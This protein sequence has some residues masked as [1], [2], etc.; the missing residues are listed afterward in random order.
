MDQ[1]SFKRKLDQMH[2]EIKAGKYENTGMTPEQVS[3][4]LVVDSGLR[5]A[6]LPVNR[7]TQ[8]QYM[9]LFEPEFTTRYKMEQRGVRLPT[10]QELTDSFAQRQYQNYFINKWNEPERPDFL[11]PQQMIEYNTKKDRANWQEYLK[12]LDADKM[13]SMVDSSLQNI[14]NEI[15]AAQQSVNTYQALYDEL[16]NEIKNYDTRRF[17]GITNKSRGIEQENTVDGKYY[18]QVVQGLEDAKAYLSSLE[19]LRSSREIEAIKDSY[20]GLDYEDQMAAVNEALAEVRGQKSAGVIMG[21]AGAAARENYLQNEDALRRREDVLED[22]RQDFQADRYLTEQDAARARLENQATRTYRT[23]YN[24]TLAAIESEI[25]KAREEARENNEDYTYTYTLN[26]QEVIKLINLTP[27][28]LA[29]YE[30][31]RKYDTAAADEYKKNLERTVNARKAALREADIRDDG[32]FV[33]LLRYIGGFFASVG[34][35]AANSLGVIRELV[36]DEYVPPDLNSDIYWGPQT[37]QTVREAFDEDIDSPMLSTIVQVGLSLTDTMMLAPF[38]VGAAMA[39]GFAS[40]RSDYTYDALQRGATF[41]EAW[42]SGIA[43]GLAET[44]AEIIPLNRIFRMARAGGKWLS[45]EGLGNIL[46]TAGMEASEETLSQYLGTVADIKIMGSRSQFVQTMQ[47]YIAAGMSEGDAY[48]A[49]VEDYFVYQPLLAAFGG[50]I[51]GAAFGTGAQG[52][53]NLRLWL[54]KRDLDRRRKLDEEAA[55]AIEKKRAREGN[56]DEQAPIAE[57]EQESATEAQTGL[58]TDRAADNDMAAVDDVMPLNNNAEADNANAEAG[59]SAAQPHTITDERQAWADAIV[60][61]EMAEEEAE[62]E[63]L[64]P[65]N[66]LTGELAERVTGVPQAKQETRQAP[67]R[68]KNPYPAVDEGDVGFGEGALDEMPDTDPADRFR[69]DLTKEEARVSAQQRRKAKMMVRALRNKGIYNVRVEDLPEGINGYYDAQTRSIVVSSRLTNEEAFNFALGHEVVHHAATADAD[70][71]DDV[72]SS[73]RADGIDVDARIAA[74]IARYR[75]HAAARGED[76][77]RIDERYAMEEVV[78]DY[79]GEICRNDAYLQQLAN[80]QPN[81]LVRILRMLEEL[82]DNLGRSREEINKAREYEAT[83]S[84]VQEALV[85]AGHEEMIEGERRYSIDYDENNRPFVTVEEDILAGVP[86]NKWVKTVKDNLRKK[87]PNSIR[88]GNNEIDINNQSRREL[89]FSR[90]MQYLFRTDR[91]LFKDKL[92]ATNNADEILQ[93]SRNWVNEALIHPRKDAIIDFARGEVLLRIGGRDYTAQVIVGNRGEGNLLLYDIINLSP[94]SIRRRQET[95]ANH[96]TKPHDEAGNRRS[97]PVSNDSILAENES[98]NR[99]YSLGEENDPDLQRAIEMQQEGYSP[100]DISNA[101][102]KV[103]MANGDI[104]SGIGGVLQY[105]PNREQGGDIGGR[106]E[107][108]TGRAGTYQGRAD[109]QDEAGQGLGEESGG[110]RNDDRRRNRADGGRVREEARGWE[111]LSGEQQREFAQIVERHLQA[112]PGSEVEMMLNA[113]ESADNDACTNI[114][115]EIYNDLAIHPALVEDRWVHFVTD[116]Q[117]MIA[118][119]DQAAARNNEQ[120]GLDQDNASNQRRYSLAKDEEKGAGRRYA[121][122]KK[123]GRGKQ[124]QSKKTGKNQEA[125]KTAEKKANPTRAMS[126]S[127]R[128]LYRL[129]NDVGQKISELLSIPN[130]A[131][132]KELRPILQKLAEE[133]R[134]TGHIS[135]ESIKEA[136][137]QAYDM[138]LI[139]DD[140]FYNQYR[141]LKGILRD[142]RITISAE[143]AANIEDYAQW[144]KKQFNKLRIVNKGGEPI[145]SFYSELAGMYPELFDPDLLSPS[146]QLQRMAEVADMIVKVEERLDDAYGDQAEQFKAAMEYEFQQEI[147]GMIDELALIKRFEESL[148]EQRSEKENPSAPRSLETMSKIYRSM[149]A[150]RR[151]KDKAVARNLLTQEDNKAVDGLLKGYYTEENLPDG[152]NRKGVLEVYRAKKEYEDLAQLIDENRKAIVAA[153]TAVVERLLETSDSWKDKKTG[154]AYSRETMERNIQDIVPD[155]DV[156]REIINTIFKPI[157]ANEAKRT[158]MK[159]EYRDRI[160][161]LK[162]SRKAAAGNRNSEAYAVQFLGEA[163]SAIDYLKDKDPNA[164]EGGLTYKEWVTAKDEFLAANPNLDMKKIDHAIAEFR[165][166]YNELFEMVNAARLRNGYAPI[167]YRRGY[168]P[169][170]MENVPDSIFG[171]MG[172]AMGINVDVVDLP[173]DI[174]GLTHMF[175]PG[176]RWEGHLLPRKSNETDYDALAGF[177]KYIEGISDI[178]FHTD[179]IQMLRIL[180]TSLRVKYGSRALADR[181]KNIQESNATLEDKEAELDELFKT[182]VLTG[183]SNFVVAIRDYTN[184]LA[185][186]KSFN[187]REMEKLASRRLYNIVKNLENLVGV[188]MVGVNPASWLTNLIP[189]AQGSAM[190]RRGFLLR[191]MWDTLR[192]Y[193]NDD[194]FWMLSDFLVNRRGSVPLALTLM[195]RAGRTAS[196]GME[197]IDQFVSDSLVRARYAQNKADGLSDAEAMAEANAF[198]ANVIADRSKGALP[199]FFESK[200]PIRK[201]FTM[202]QVEVNNQLSFLF[203]DLPREARREGSKA[204]AAMFLQ[205]ALASWLFDEIYELLIGRRPALDPVNIL[206]DFVGDITGYQLPNLLS[207]VGDAVS[208]EEIEWSTDQEGLGQSFVNFLEAGAENVPFVGGL[209]GGGRLPVQ[210]AIPNVASLMEAVGDLI[211]GDISRDKALNNILDELLPALSYLATPFGGGALKKIIEGSVAV[212]QDGSYTLDNEGNKILQYPIYNDSTLQTIGNFIKAITF[213]KSSLSTGVAWVDDN[214][215]NLSARETAAYLNLVGGGSNVEDVYETLRAMKAEKK[216]LDKRLELMD[217]PL[218][219]YEKLTIYETVLYNEGDSRPEDIENIMATGVSFDDAM[220][221]QNK[222]NILDDIDDMTAKEKAGEFAYW[223]DSN[224]FTEDQQAVAREAFKFYSRIE[225][226]PGEINYDK[227]TAAGLDEDVAH[228]VEL[229]LGSL[230]PLIGE[231]EVLDAQKHRAIADL[232]ISDNDKL[233]AF[234]GIMNESSYKKISI[235]YDTGVEPGDYVTFREYLDE[236]SEGDNAT[237][238]EAVKA[239]NRMTWLSASEKAVLYQLANS[240][241]VPKNNPYSTAIGSRVY[242]SLK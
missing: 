123:E 126:K 205:F 233:K 95:G 76:P 113:Y 68:E 208:G 5:K 82:L 160:R 217:A 210:T 52:V 237:Q 166:I 134:R 232:D 163:N 107:Q 235:A 40:A 209:L 225:A 14:D 89:T 97:A 224:D 102:G 60:E 48:R 24:D 164:V 51:A 30:T 190:L 94:T 38:G 181:I 169:H 146:A 3:G 214:F 182:D 92:K 216:S 222:Y 86:K 199:T 1:Q 207:V 153:R 41:Q 179:D 228:E 223:L 37:R 159:N 13:A 108:E 227:M 103:V 178:V 21:R 154:F 155:P 72:I 203:K 221:I 17:A 201:L 6:Q 19:E 188:N 85:K 58:E 128:Y 73:M 18:A 45:K 31:L 67:E 145:D 20:S 219:D 44:I 63:A 197:I 213:G 131:R 229:A 93:A 206:N 111:E 174:N 104:Y 157:H 25:K 183:L 240:G 234:K 69:Q 132:R 101:T 191:G 162:L 15:K 189:L 87:F 34:A 33:N 99:R 50:G 115:K 78:A 100:T 23:S 151:A 161:K 106:R 165:M 81:L 54:R 125:T 74:V 70:L 130:S 175:R 91:Q 47:E 8:G 135:D 79:I 7:E 65:D 35:G 61:R 98:V 22:V 158:K 2:A 29:V 84:R 171:K 56:Q 202:F 239:L 105:S 120:I 27:E 230:T 139:I 215:K 57:D 156:A 121:L 200:N 187:D 88:V 32:W 124:K 192:S 177:D 42:I 138:G 194:G 242:Y 49:A 196:K 186:K 167:D 129:I 185:N 117:G 62:E 226:K 59:S 172:Q 36:T 96:I 212:A 198:A 218:S 109:N 46:K 90:Y 116:L 66:F 10:Y 140:D 238:A 176:I 137:N 110:P 26:G 4:L 173:T 220:R 136:F 77:S 241:W 83:I 80:D 112:E 43:A 204:L 149:R 71:V 28:E 184:V 148:A 195:E 193:K 133:Y 143:D 168:F 122:T 53:G 127:E 64:S 180:E 144:R 231:D 39:G 150:A 16:E 12:L 118:E 11:T 75:R 119:F 170:F 9:K 236:E 114:A 141:D 142:T 55:A 147:Y 152:I 211:D